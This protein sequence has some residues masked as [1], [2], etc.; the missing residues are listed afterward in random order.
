MLGVEGA[1]AEAAAMAREICAGVPPGDCSSESW[2][3]DSSGGIVEDGCVEDDGGVG[4]AV[5]S[6]VSVSDDSVGLEPAP[7]EDEASAC[8]IGES[9][10]DPDVP[11]ISFPLVIS[12]GD[13]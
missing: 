6:S 12:S 5:D 4:V 9:C 11:S 2:V 8:S 7:T 13:I 1:G 10:F 3:E